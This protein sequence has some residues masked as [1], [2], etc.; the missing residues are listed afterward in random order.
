MAK[1]ILNL[2]AFI[3]KQAPVCLSII[4][5]VTEFHIIHKSDASNLFLLLDLVIGEEISRYG[6]RKDVINFTSRYN[7]P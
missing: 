7:T 5:W 4:P 6:W 1:T 2:I 3:Q